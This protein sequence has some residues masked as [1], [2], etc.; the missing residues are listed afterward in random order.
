MGGPSL[1]RAIRWHE[2]QSSDA[3]R[4]GDTPE[5]ALAALTSDM[6]GSR[7]LSAVPRRFLAPNI[8]SDRAGVEA[9]ELRASALISR[10]R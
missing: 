1:L 6:S 2:E 9:T 8:G 10:N 4:L 7:I 5:T 3:F